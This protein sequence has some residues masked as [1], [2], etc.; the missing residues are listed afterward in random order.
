MAYIHRPGYGRWLLSNFL[1]IILS[2]LASLLPAVLYWVMLDAY[3]ANSKG[4]ALTLGTALVCVPLSV[5]AVFAGWLV[6]A[7]V[8]HS[9]MSEWANKNVVLT[10]V[11]IAGLMLSAMAVNGVV[12]FI[13]IALCLLLLPLIFMR[14]GDRDPG[15]GTVLVLGAVLAAAAAAVGPL[16]ALASEIRPL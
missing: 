7:G 13:G 4:D 10:V 8:V 14:V 11:G 12:A 1:G 15:R 9:R 6:Y 3:I 5:C 2:V 16:V